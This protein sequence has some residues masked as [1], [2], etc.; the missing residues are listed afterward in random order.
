MG[1]NEVVEYLD[2]LV[3]KRGVSAKTQATALGEFQESCRLKLK[4]KKQSLCSYF[5]II[6]ICVCAVLCRPAVVSV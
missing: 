3:L 5:K 4:K 1:D 2:Y 6:C